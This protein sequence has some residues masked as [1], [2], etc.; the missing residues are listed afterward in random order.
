MEWLT[1]TAG[2]GGRTMLVKLGAQTP[3]DTHWRLRVRGGRSHVTASN[4]FAVS[5]GGGVLNMSGAVLL[6]QSRMPSS[7]FSFGEKCA[8]FF[9]WVGTSPSPAG[10]P[11]TARS[12]LEIWRQGIP[13]EATPRLPMSLP[14]PRSRTGLSSG[15]RGRSLLGESGE[16]GSVK[17]V[18]RPSESGDADRARAEKQRMAL[19]GDN[20]ERD[21]DESPKRLA[22]P[23]RELVSSS[24]WTGVVGSRLTSCAG[25]SPW[26][27]GSVPAAYHR[28]TS[29]LQTLRASS[30]S[31]LAQATRRSCLRRRRDPKPLTCLETKKPLAPPEAENFVATC[32]PLGASGSQVHPHAHGGIAL[33]TAS[34]ALPEPRLE[35]E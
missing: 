6:R 5:T 31:A 13:T 1:A 34:S 4:L 19:E 23:V 30:G 28:L 24:Q 9:I 29:G 20:A 26:G 8:T 14:C 33:T 16:P 7:L 22:L 25:A 35:L 32:S 2:S 11:A 3:A 21:G 17:I 15:L 27:S 10:N 12:W 18:E